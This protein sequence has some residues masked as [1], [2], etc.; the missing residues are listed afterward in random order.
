MIAWDNIP[1]MMEKSGVNCFRLVQGSTKGGK[2]RAIK[3]LHEF[4]SEGE[5]GEAIAEFES[6]RGWYEGLPN[7]N[8]QAGTHESV[9]G[10]WS[11]ANLWPMEGPEKENPGMMGM[12][13]MYG[14]NNPLAMMTM[15]NNMGMINSDVMNA[16]LETQKAQFDYMTKMGEMEARLMENEKSI[17]PAKYDK[18]VDLIIAREMGMKPEELVALH[19]MYGQQGQNQPAAL[20]G[21]EVQVETNPPAAPA[22]K[23]VYSDLQFAEI[24]TVI[25]G[26]EEKVPFSDFIG[27][28]KAVQKDPEVI[29][30]AK[31]F[32]NIK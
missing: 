25:E 5:P 24:Q 29:Q 2:G 13:K 14:M 3:K 9:N 31:P 7:V 32:L 22:A 16:K 10:N 12:P 1:E 4:K 23:K 21:Q 17:V 11:Q 8:M 27:L 26:F 6:I 18:W 20:S 28:L 30:K 19:Q 15:M